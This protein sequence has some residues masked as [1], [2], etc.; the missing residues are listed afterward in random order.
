[1]NEASYTV[2]QLEAILNEYDDLDDDSTHVD[3]DDTSILDKQF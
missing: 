2:A 1:L 3:D